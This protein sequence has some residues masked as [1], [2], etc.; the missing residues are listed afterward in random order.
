MIFQKHR[1]FVLLSI[2]L[3]MIPIAF[4]DS[5]QRLGVSTKLLSPAC[6]LNPSN[7]RGLKL[8][9]YIC[10]QKPGN[11]LAFKV[12]FIQFYSDFN[13]FSIAFM[14][15]STPK[16][17]LSEYKSLISTKCSWLKT[18]AISP[19][20]INKISSQILFSESKI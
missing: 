18:F 9:L 17:M 2:A 19:S 3:E 15:L 10:S 7:S 11:S 4:V 20:F 13:D 16:F 1:V 6:F 5:I 12:Y 14:M 8:G